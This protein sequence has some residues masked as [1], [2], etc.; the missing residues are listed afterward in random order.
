MWPAAQ[1][2]PPT[3]NRSYVA[4]LQCT[5]Y[6]ILY[7]HDRGLQPLR[8]PGCTQNGGE[9][10]SF[11]ILSIGV[12]GL[13]VLSASSADYINDNKIIIIILLSFSKLV[14]CYIVA[15]IVPIGRYS[16]NIYYDAHETAT[17]T[18]M[19]IIITIIITIC[20]VM[21]NSTGRPTSSTRRR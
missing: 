21:I 7:Y 19:M 11:G 12:T 2:S 6:I 4:H 1:C 20:V 8:V 18:T 3:T 14:D 17:K 9:F 5:F 10:G 13:R 15:P 16:Y